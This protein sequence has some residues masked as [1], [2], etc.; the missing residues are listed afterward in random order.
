[1]FK[2]QSKSRK[3]FGLKIVAVIK[4]G[5]HF[6][7][8]FASVRFD[9]N[10]AQTNQPIIKCTTWHE[11]WLKAVEQLYTHAVFIDSGTVFIDW[12]TWKADLVKYPNKGLVAHIVWHPGEQPYIH[13]QCWFAQLSLLTD[14]C[15]KAST[16]TYAAPVR[17]EDNIHDDYTPLYIQPGK[18]EPETHTVTE[19]GQS[20]IANFLNQNRGVVNWHRR[21]REHKMYLYSNEPTAKQRWNNSQEQYYEIAENQLWVLNNE[22]V[23]LLSGKHQLMPGAGVYWLL[24]IIQPH[25]QSLK[26]LDISKTQVQYCR[27]LW[28]RWD[29]S[30]LGGFASEFVK[31]NQLTH[32]EF[33]NTEMSAEERMRLRSPRHMREY[34]NTAF[35]K[36]CRDFGIWEFETL[37][38][39][40]HSVE[41]EAQQGDLVEYVN[42]K[43]LGD[44]DSVWV[45]NILDYKWTLLKNEHSVVSEFYKTLDDL[46]VEIL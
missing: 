41:F 45:S 1:M 8:T 4:D 15:F 31:H 24:N 42:R 5:P 40:R 3:S 22:P 23:R 33:D 35:D 39:R 14:N 21:M 43:T 30:D 16:A 46:Q 32:I 27:A 44:V 34:V 29:G 18:S 17:S 10:G 6:A 9:R 38:Q 11:G 25:T 26:I 7:K 20:L 2:N 19:F 37:W 12:N 36:V 28:E 13:D